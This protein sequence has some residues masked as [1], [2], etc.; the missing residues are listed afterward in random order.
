MV[1]MKFENYY[2]IDMGLLIYNVSFRRGMLK[3]Q[4]QNTH[5]HH[6]PYHVSSW[7]VKVWKRGNNQ[8]V[9]PKW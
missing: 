6:I 3:Q 2:M 8:T 4:P 1:N 9:S 7:L 5:I